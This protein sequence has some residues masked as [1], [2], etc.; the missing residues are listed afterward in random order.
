MVVS[1]WRK[2]PFD[3]CLRF[4]DDGILQ[5]KVYIFNLDWIRWADGSA[6]FDYLL[7]ADR[8]SSPSV[9]LR[10]V[11][12]CVRPGQFA[13]YLRLVKVDEIYKEEWGLYMCC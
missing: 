5:R 7:A 6:S 9:C 4:H 11:L 13:S 3:E 8:D 10:F 2:L 12:H 1:L